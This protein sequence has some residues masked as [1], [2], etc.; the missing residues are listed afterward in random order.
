MGERFDP[1]ISPS[2]GALADWMR[3]DY[4]LFDNRHFLHELRTEFCQMLSP[5]EFPMILKD[6]GTP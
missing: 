1:Q 4:P 3:V 5:E 2:A 6:E